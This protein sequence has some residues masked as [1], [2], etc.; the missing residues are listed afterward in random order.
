MA[1]END[2]LPMLTDDN[3]HDLLSQ[4]QVST[5]TNGEARL[6]LS[7]CMTVYLFQTSKMVYAPC[8]KSESAGANANCLKGGTAVYNSECAGRIEQ[9]IQTPTADISP[10]GTWIT[11]AFL[12]DKQLTITVVMKGSAEVR[13]VID[14]GTRSLGEPTTINEGQYSMTTT[15]Q[16]ANRQDFEIAKLRQPKSLGEMP[17]ELRTYLK[18]WMDRIQKHATQDELPRQSYAFTADID[19]D[20]AQLEFG[21]RLPCVRGEA[22]MWKR[23]YE[24]GDMGKCDPE[25]S[26]P[27]AR[28]K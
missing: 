16:Q 7:G 11:V 25:T 13:P 10:R 4:T 3:W 27:N 6:R 19:C 9:L 1:G 21:S 18:P 26:G 12:E 14:M 8:S 5:D 17:T 24:T 28:P 15:D 2:P 22:Q 20:C 23:F